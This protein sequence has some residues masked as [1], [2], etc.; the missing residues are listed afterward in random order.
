MRYIVTGG[1]GFIGSNLARKLVGEGHDV[2]V[3]DNFHTG[4]MDNL[5]GLEKKIQVIKGQSCDI[6]KPILEDADGLFHLGIPSSTP[7]YR[8]N[9]LLVGET[10]NE[11]I[12]ILNN[13]PGRIVF[14]S[15]SSV[16]NGCNI[17]YIEDMTLVPTDYYTET[18]IA[19]ERLARVYWDM[20][21]NKTVALRMFSV[22]GPGE[23]WKGRY[24]NMV[25]Q[26]L[27]EMRDGRRPIIYGDGSQTR[28][29]THVDD[30]VR[31]FI[32]AME[33]KLE[34]DMFNK[35]DVFNVGTGS[36]YSFNDVVQMINDALNLRKP[37]KPVYVENTLKNYV[38]HTKANTMKARM[39]LNFTASVS[40]EEGI[41]RLLYDF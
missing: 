4:S 5:K 16:Y 36:S 26:I 31:A 25:S 20:Q 6:P 41:K 17:P 3:V 29:F 24:A 7:M 9:R 32:L 22:Y 23:W 39:E 11:F 35:D 2:T 12:R 30:A 34:H 18:R 33:T 8:E 19:M 10:I 1:A 14:A 15:S 13:Y 38:I 40:L 27:W 21:G 37:L 28:D